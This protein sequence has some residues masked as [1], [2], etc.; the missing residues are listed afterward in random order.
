MT[1][2]AG[3]RLQA[4]VPVFVKATDEQ[5]ICNS[6]KGYQLFLVN[7]DNEV[8]VETWVGAVAKKNP[9]KREEGET[10]KIVAL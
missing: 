1:S 7:G 5:I 10:W 8:L 6:T 4:H 9:Y 2:S 3:F